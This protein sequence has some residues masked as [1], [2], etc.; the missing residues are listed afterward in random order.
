MR[1]RGFL[2]TTSPLPEGS[3]ILSEMMGGRWANILL[4]SREKP[5]SPH[6]ELFE[7]A[8][9]LNHKFTMSNGIGEEPVPYT[10]QELDELVESVLSVTLPPPKLAEEAGPSFRMN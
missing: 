7:I 6:A 4:S 10:G 9:R 3:V 5:D 1:A 2:E 8:G